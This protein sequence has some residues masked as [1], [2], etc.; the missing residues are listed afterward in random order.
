MASN[1]ASEVT[2]AHKAVIE[3]L[4]LTSSPEVML[5]SRIP[6]FGDDSSESQLQRGIYL[7]TAG[8]ELGRSFS[9]RQDMRFGTVVLLCAGRSTVQAEPGERVLLDWRRELIDTF[10][11]RRVT[12]L[13]CELLTQ[14]E[15]LSFS[16]SARLKRK[17]DITGLEIWSYFRESRP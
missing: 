14:V 11:N 16:L 3:G 13:D 17:F 8:E 1:S 9:S 2:A 10:H 5:R 7:A 12:D 6:G 4:S 15:G